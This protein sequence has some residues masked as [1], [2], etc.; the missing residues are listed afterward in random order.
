MNS[1]LVFLNKPGDRSPQNEKSNWQELLRNIEAIPKK[2]ASTEMPSDNAWHI[3]LPEGWP[4]LVELIA[5]ATKLKIGSR[6][7]LFDEAPKWLCAP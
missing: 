7:L 6:M 2:P 5:Q 1:A 3:P 4:F